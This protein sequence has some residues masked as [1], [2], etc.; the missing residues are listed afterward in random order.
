MDL[1]IANKSALVT[2]STSGIGFAIAKELSREGVKVTINGRDRSRVDAAVARLKEELPEACVE[3]LAADLSTKSGV[4]SVINSLK[5]VDILVNNLGIFKPEPFESISDEDWTRFF[6]VNVMSGVRLSQ[7]YLPLM[8]ENGWGRI[9]FISS[10][11]GVNPPSEMIHY[12]MT[13]AAQLSISR[14][15]AQL[16]TGTSVTV[17]AILPGP[18]KSEG[19]AEFFNNL[20]R[21]QNISQ[22]EMEALFFAEVRPTSILKRMADPSEVAALVTYVCSDRASATNGAALRVDGGVVSTMY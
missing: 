2:G 3:G 11:S 13:K 9:I 21:E 16:T 19:V 15:L 5:T 8:K 12:G 20:A 6:E 14:G 18:T 1:K 4:D 22:D 7:Y 10:E 17:N